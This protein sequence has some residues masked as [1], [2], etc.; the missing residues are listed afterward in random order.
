MAE[1]LRSDCHQLRLRIQ[2]Q[3][4]ESETLT[5]QLRL[6]KISQF[7]HLPNIWECPHLPDLSNL[8]AE[9]SQSASD[10]L[11]LIRDVKEQL[12]RKSFLDTQIDELQKKSKTLG[13]AGDALQGAID[14]M[15][16]RQRAELAAVDESRE[17][18]QRV[19]AETAA[20]RERLQAASPAAAA[21][22]EEVRA[23]LRRAAH[24]EEQIRERR[25][26]HA[27]LVAALEAQIAQCNRRLD[28]ARAVEA[29]LRKKTAQKRTALQSEI[30]KRRGI[31][32]H[33]SR[34]ASR[35]D[36]A[37]LF[38]ESRM[39]IEQLAKRQQEVW[40][41]EERVPFVRNTRDILGRDILRR[42]FGG[43]QGEKGQQIGGV[44]LKMVLELAE[45]ERRQR[46]LAD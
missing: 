39:L 45:I 6:V 46:E 2:Q 4:K 9:L 11:Q 14:E 22:P 18:L 5:N 31:V 20:L 34:T 12:N 3:Q 21:N 1:R 19:E 16:G 13:R 41:L 36:A 35:K 40:D 8:P 17:R 23:A 29:V 38:L 42:L 44:A 30:N 24:A 26:R 7:L 37:G 43:A 25:E 28:D 15:R 10:V 32:V 27:A 33:S